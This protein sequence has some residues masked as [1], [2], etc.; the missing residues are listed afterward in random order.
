MGSA[1][2]PA[3]LPLRGAAVEA[4]QRAGGVFRNAECLSVAGARFRGNGLPTIS[5]SQFYSVFVFRSRARGGAVDV[6][7]TRV[8]A[9]FVLRRGG[10]LGFGGALPGKAFWILEAPR[11]EFRGSWH[12]VA[13]EQG[14]LD[15]A[16]QAEVYD[17]RILGLEAAPA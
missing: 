16:D 14:L 8:D 6:L 4:G 9:I 12:G 1:G 15:D 5:G 13:S 11:S 17:G 10:C 7:A 2:G 3:R